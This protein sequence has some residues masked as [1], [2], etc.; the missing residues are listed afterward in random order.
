MG[1]N[2]KYG[3]H[4]ESH[5]RPHGLPDF[6]QIE[7]DQAQIE[8]NQRFPLFF[9]ELRPFFLE[10]AE[11]FRIQ[12]P[13]ILVHTRTI[14]DPDYGAK[15]SGKV[16]RVSLGVLAT[17][18]RAPGNVADPDVPLFDQS[19]YTFIGRGLYEVYAESTV[20]AMITDREFMDSHSRMFDLDGNLRL[21][22]TTVFRF[23][24]VRTLHKELDA[25]EESGHMLTARWVRGGRHVNWDLFLYE[26]SP[27][28][29]TD[30]GFVRRADVRQGSAELGYRFWPETWLISWGP[31][32]GYIRNY[33]FDGVLQDE[34]LG[35]ST[36]FQFAKNIN[37]SGTVTRDMERFLGTDFESTRLWIQGRVNTSRTYQFGANFS[38]G[39]QVRYSDTPFLGHG[40]TWGLKCDAQADLPTADQSQ[41]ERKPADGS[42]ERRE[43][44]RR[45]DPA[46]ANRRPTHRSDRAAEHR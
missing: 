7:S 28:L 41:L 29:D 23:R 22:P 25:P 2:L 11:I 31:H 37:L 24:A 26:I 20:G 13:V 38:A 4:V 43:G 10:G 19:A 46:D 5:G 18:D 34:N 8:V 21:N 9:R 6:S 35:F 12:A 42:S 3:I 1:I 30:V 14:V 27:D 33:D 39:D 15:L 45:E 16:G 40:T 32:V 44:L 36:E 17:N